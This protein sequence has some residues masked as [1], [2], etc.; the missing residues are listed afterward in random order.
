MQQD[1]IILR[2]G[3]V[4][5]LD[6]ELGYP[7]Y[8]EQQLDI[9]PDLNE[10]FTGHIFKIMSGD[11]MKKCYFDEESSDIYKLLKDFSEDDFIDFSKD[12]TKRLYD[13]MNSNLAIPS[14]DLAV[15]SFSLHSVMYLAILKMNYKESFV[16][17]TQAEESGNVN[18]IIKYRS[19]LP[20]S[21][22][23]LSEAVII[24]LGDYT[25]NIIEKK[26]EVNGEKC[27]Y[28]ST[29]WSYILKT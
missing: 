9:T 1:E 10:F 6:G 23:K 14:A 28:L 29:K 25:V 13:I 12:I 11:D 19:T 16:H 18:S 26:Y 4:H 27:N 8:S 20:A 22:S 17:M 21:S 15:L 2:K 7:V 24:N 5:I 3:I